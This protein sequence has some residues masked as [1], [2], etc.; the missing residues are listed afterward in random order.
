VFVA[1]FAVVALL[2]AWG[3]YHRLTEL[4]LLTAAVRNEVARLSSTLATPTLPAPEGAEMD[5][6]GPPFGSLRNLADL[7]SAYVAAESP[8]LWQSPTRPKE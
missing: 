5:D 4:V 8:R 2:L 6:T 1:L 3:I 7:R